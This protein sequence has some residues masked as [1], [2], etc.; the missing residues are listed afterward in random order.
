M[1]SPLSVAGVQLASQARGELALAGV[2]DGGVAPGWAW[3]PLAGR[4]TELSGE[5]CLTL[6]FDLLFD[7]QQR[8][9]PVA[10]VTC[11]DSLFFV[12]DALARG[13]DLAALPI[14]RVTNGMDAGRAADHL[15]RSGAFGAVLVDLD[16]QQSVPPALE[17]RL[18]GLAQKHRCAIVFLS[19]RSSPRSQRRSQTIPRSPTLVSLRVEAWREAVG[20]AR[21]H[22]G[23]RLLKDKRHGPTWSYEDVYDGPPGLR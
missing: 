21:F 12:T 13:I 10:W 7:A 2:A 15:A 23:V 14:V 3:E 16:P 22:C 18:L 19:A 4:L 5:A 11:R 20:E 6:A 1:P 9:E 17:S 8:T